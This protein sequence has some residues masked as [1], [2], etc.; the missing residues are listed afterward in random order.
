MKKIVIVVVI[1]SILTSC[2]LIATFKVRDAFDAEYVQPTFFKK[3]L[4]FELIEG[5][6]VV[7]VKIGGQEERLILD[8]GA[9]TSIDDSVR[10]RL[11]VEKLGRIKTFDSNGNKRYIEYGKVE[12]IEVANIP[13][14]DI[15]VTHSNLSLLKRAACLDVA[16]ILGV[17]LMNKAIWQIDYSTQFITI[18]NDRDS[19]DLGSEY[20]RVHFDAIGKG[21]PMMAVYHNNTYIDDAILDTGFRGTFL[22]GNSDSFGQEYVERKV[23]TI[24]AFSEEQINQRVYE[25][26]GIN[27]GRE[28]LLDTIL[29]T[30]EEGRKGSFI[31]NSFLKEYLVTLDWGYQEM[32]IAPRQCLERERKSFGVGLHLKEESVVVG[33]LF[34]NMPLYKTGLRIGDE[35]LEINTIDFEENTEEAY[36]QYM[37]ERNSWNSIVIKARTETGIRWFESRKID[38]SNWTN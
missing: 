14:Y 16:G 33:S 5:L 2:G 34:T 36:C 18:T 10:K 21:T 20:T 28:L 25:L 31:G 32:I 37:K 4:A 12:K 30:T 24:G 17:N 27:I 1:G 35:V 9:T 7:K 11:S 3:V 26:S 15:V 13:F 29:L 8:T 23:T 19:L 22:L 6:I 38:I